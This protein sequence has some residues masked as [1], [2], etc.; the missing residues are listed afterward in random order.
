[1]SKPEPTPL[2]AMSVEQLEKHIADMEKT[3]KA[4]RK[5]LIALLRAKQAMTPVVV[6]VDNQEQKDEA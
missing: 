1:M 5:A 3:H 4:T 2:D 6:L